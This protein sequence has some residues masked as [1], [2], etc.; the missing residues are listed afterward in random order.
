MK[1]YK[2][3]K[4]HVVLIFIFITMHINAQEGYKIFLWGMTSQQ[5]KEKCQDLEQF[6][7]NRWPAPSYA[8]MFFYTN[9]L[10]TTI[11]NPLAQE[12]GEIT[13][14]KS[15]ENELKFYFIDNGLVAVEIFFFQEN[16]R[17][18]LEKLH[19]SISPVQGAYGNYRYETGAWKDQKNRTIVW[20][21]AGYGMEN[22]TYIKNDW[23]SIL[24]NKTLNQVMQNNENT[25]SKLD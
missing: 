9:D 11:P 14:Y 16:I 2:L 1:F 22:V 24:I 3:R 8:L 17:T 20:E 19:G 13:C 12:S 5:V 25:R 15:K 4:L 21:N 10:D 6:N 23:L 7:T 18:E